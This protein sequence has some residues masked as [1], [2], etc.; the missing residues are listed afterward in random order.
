MNKSRVVFLDS[1]VYIRCCCD[2]SEDSQ[3]NK[4]SKFIEKN[5]IRLLTTEIVKDEVENKIKSRIEDSFKKIKTAEFSV[6]RNFIDL[7]EKDL[8]EKNIHAFES[9]L[10]RNRSL[11]L[12]IDNINIHEV[13]QDY[14]NGKPPFSNVKKKSEFPDAFNISIIEA[15]AVDNPH[16]EIFIIS[17]DK[18]FNSIDSMITLKEISEFQDRI[19]KENSHIQ[20]L[21][22][23]YIKNNHAMI[24]SELLSSLGEVYRGELIDHITSYLELVRN[25]TDIEDIEIKK[26]NTTDGFTLRVLEI[27]N[28]NNTISIEITYI[29]ETILDYSYLDIEQ[30][31]WDSIDGDFYAVYG[32][33]KNEVHRLT[34][35][36]S[37]ECLRRYA[38]EVTDH[39]IYDMQIHHNGN[40]DLY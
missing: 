18:D 13:W 38:S 37:I 2:F 30:S 26:I 24:K 31:K 6:V 21:I 11:M 15:Y 39:C 19:N 22:D 10:E 1:S 34:C 35:V 33:K 17:H 5:N 28:D 20:S 25:I 3:L 23:N 32:N 9:Y 8:L 7:N 12:S 27:N 29:I 14:I 4:F 40:L 36:V 16:S